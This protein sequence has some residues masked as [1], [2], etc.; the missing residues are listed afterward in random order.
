[1]PSIQTLLIDSSALSATDQY[2]QWAADL[3]VSATETLQNM[4]GDDNVW[5]FELA[6]ACLEAGA[7]CGE[8]SSEGM[9]GWST[10]LKRNQPMATDFSRMY[11]AG[12]I[13]PDHLLGFRYSLD[14]KSVGVK[15]QKSGLVTILGGGIAQLG[16]DAPRIDFAVRFSGVLNEPP[17]LVLTVGSGPPTTRVGAL[18]LAPETQNFASEV[19]PAGYSYAI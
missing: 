10:N 4:D 1:M 18:R 9:V 3:G 17:H 16:T 5:T 2:A 12:G 15:L 6:A 7:I 11:Y 13:Q 8:F 19:L 14:C